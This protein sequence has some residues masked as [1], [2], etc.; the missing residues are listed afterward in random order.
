MRFIDE[1]SIQ[2]KSGNGGAGAVSFRREKFVPRGGPDGGD[3]GRGGSIFFAADEN[4][5]TLIHFRGK[6]YFFAEEG[7]NGA[8]AQRTGHSGEHLILKVPVGT[9]IKDQ[10]SDEVLFD[11]AE[12]GQTIEVLKGGRGGLGNV[13]FKSSTNQSPRY[14]QEGETGQTL[15]ISL[16]LKL[17]ADV[18][19]VGLPNAGKSTLISTISA[20]KPKIADYPF[21]TL[22]PNLGVIALGEKSM[23]VADIPGLIE[24]A[25]LGKGLGIKFLRHIERTRALIHLV[26]ISWCLDEF[27]A[28]ESYVT[29]RQELE[30]Y[31][32]G[33]DLKP[34][35]VCLTKIDA[36]RMEE[37]TKYQQFFEEQL[38]KKVIPLSAVGHQN[39]D[40]LKA[41]M[42]KIKDSVQ[43]PA[44]KEE[45][46]QPVY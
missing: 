42:F 2:I 43:P 27:E 36:L 44:F 37:I 12:H 40:L 9:M 30:K 17:I 38:D 20:A 34:E 41:V 6:K 25:S 15:D 26:D 8:G 46:E 23:V 1:V 5:N 10:A 21:T 11:L 7:K 39:I 22:E 13:N 14:A 19:L 24:E 45:N 31:G 4:L 3:G 29:I 32:K 18:A 35:I 28:Y 33:L 16:E